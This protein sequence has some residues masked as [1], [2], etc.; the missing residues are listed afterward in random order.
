MPSA[1]AATGHL[2][3]PWVIGSSV[4][5]LALLYGVWWTTLRRD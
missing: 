4:A 3:V 2:P 1:D 5:C